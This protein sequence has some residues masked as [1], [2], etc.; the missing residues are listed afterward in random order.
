MRYNGVSELNLLLYSPFSKACPKDEPTMLGET[1]L[2]T[3]K[4]QEKPKA[5]S[6]PNWLSIEFRCT[7]VIGDE[8]C[9]LRKQNRQSWQKL[10]KGR[11]LAG[12][13]LRTGE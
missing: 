2:L 11:L 3:I 12:L 6:P 9:L 10:S 1:T 7:Y 4:A 5:I 13:N 8:L